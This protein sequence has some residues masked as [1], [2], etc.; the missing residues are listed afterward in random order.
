MS[1]CPWYCD[2]CPESTVVQ[3]REAN[4]QR[5]IADAIASLT[6]ERDDWKEQCLIAQEQVKR[7]LHKE[8]SDV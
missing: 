8:Q 7:L 2:C 1:L 5:R 3:L 6:A 4:V